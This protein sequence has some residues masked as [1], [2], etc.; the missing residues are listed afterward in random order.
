MYLYLSLTG[1]SL[2]QIPTDSRLGMSKLFPYR[3]TSSGQDVNESI[4]Q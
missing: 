1:S 4:T 3:S 2:I